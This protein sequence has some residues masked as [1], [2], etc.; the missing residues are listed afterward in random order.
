M[1]ATRF[2]QPASGVSERM[3]GFIAHL[4]ANGYNVGVRE[5]QS[6]LTVLNKL[7][8]ENSHEPRLACQAILAKR[9]DQYLSLTSCLMRIGSIAVARK[10]QLPK[11]TASTPEKIRAVSFGLVSI[12]LRWTQARVGQINRM[13]PTRTM[14]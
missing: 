12:T 11:L 8:L 3:S 6:V 14:K 5:T 2:V 1:R 4:R 9:S 7:A 10:V 13:R